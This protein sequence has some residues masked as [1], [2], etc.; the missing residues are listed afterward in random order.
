M[1]IKTIDEMEIATKNEWKQLVEKI[2]CESKEIEKLLDLVYKNEKI[3]SP[4]D[5]E[6]I[7]KRICSQKD[8]EGRHI[9]ADRLM[10]NLLEKLGYGKGIEIFENTEKWYA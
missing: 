6:L 5:F 3:L 2:A 9:D 8:K 4:K 1:K 7:M 10:C